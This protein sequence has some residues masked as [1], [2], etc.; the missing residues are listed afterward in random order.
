MN[1]VKILQ[2]KF[3]ILEAAHAKLIAA[4]VKLK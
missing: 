2:T 4:H 1:T 3:N